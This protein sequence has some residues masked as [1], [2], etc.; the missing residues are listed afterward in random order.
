MKT[1]AVIVNQ[2]KSGT[3]E[4]L[5]KLIS[6]ANSLGLEL[7]FEADD[8]SWLPNQ[9][10]LDCDDLFSRA[11]AV[12]TLGGDGTLLSA[13]RRMGHCPLPLL[14]I[15]FGKL[16]FLTS[17]TQDQVDQALEA[18]ANGTCITSR[19]PLLACS[20]RNPGEE[21]QTVRVL[22]DVVM[23]WGKS[24][25]IATLEVTVNGGELTTYTCDGL[26]VSTPTGSTGHSLSAGGPILSPETEDLVL[27]PICP[28]SMTVRPVVLSSRSTLGIQLAP[29]SKSLVLACDGQP[30]LEMVP[31]AK[32]DIQFCHL[33]IELLQLPDYNYWEVLRNKLHWRGSSVE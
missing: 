2:E 31:G 1:L 30:V 33:G 19:R 29:H 11:D 28:H 20:F 4:I 16:G 6:K 13:V 12:L 7:L 18:L 23:S 3:R 10:C 24:S 21:A 27:S 15:N 17:V 26:I 8:A 9:T 5:P 32:L 14:G 22:N 25:H